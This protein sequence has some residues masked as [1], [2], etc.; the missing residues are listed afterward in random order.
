MNEIPNNP[1]KFN[2]EKIM[3]G[4]EKQSAYTLIEFLIKEHK[5]R[6]DVISLS[7][8]EDP[9]EELYREMGISRFETDDSKEKKYHLAMRVRTNDDKKLDLGKIN[10][11]ATIK[12]G[13]FE[14]I[15]A[16]VDFLSQAAENL[17]FTQS[18]DEIPHIPGLMRD[19]ICHLVANEVFDFWYS[20]NPQALSPG[21]KKMYKTILELASDD[22][23]T[24]SIYT[25]IKISLEKESYDGEERYKLSA[26]K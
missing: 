8:R 18:D 19:T 5:V 1:Q 16:L 2:P 22:I 7:A 14:K 23:D 12:N 24:E 25:K 9:L 26:R 6:V 3:S 4:L 10:G 21:G 11:I 15:V 20:S 13:K 17:G